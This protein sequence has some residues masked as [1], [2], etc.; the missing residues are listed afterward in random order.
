MTTIDSTDTA[1]RLAIVRRAFSIRRRGYD[2][3]EVDELLDTV[4]GLTDDLLGEIDATSRHLIEAEAELVGARAELRELREERTASEQLLATTRAELRELREVRTASEQLLATTRAELRAARQDSARDGEAE[5]KLV[6]A[7]AERRLLRAS[8]EHAEAALAE[9]RELLSLEQAARGTVE[10]Q[11]AEMTTQLDAVSAQ[12]AVAA[13]QEACDPFA[14]V[15][16]EIA[17]LLRAAASSAED[18]RRRAR[19]EADAMVAEAEELATALLEDAESSAVV[20]EAR[21][22]TGAVLE[23]AGEALDNHEPFAM[24]ING[25][26]GD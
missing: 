6:V 1:L 7:E 25:A 10:A 17:G 14:E 2:T 22:A 23:Q 15:G 19:E 8:V 5:E 11:L 12:L 21:A 9:A 18:V 4:S 3:A 24:E 20:A 16:A 13:G 26:D